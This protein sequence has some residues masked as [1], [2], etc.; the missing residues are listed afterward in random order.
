MSLDN[1]EKLAALRDKGI[2]SQEEF[3]RE[4]A[5]IFRETNSKFNESER[6]KAE[7]SS[8]NSSIEPNAEMNKESDQT[9][10]SNKKPFLFNL[11]ESGF[12]YLI[13]LSILA[14]FLFNLGILITVI[15]WLSEK[16]KSSL[17]NLHGKNA[18]NWQISYLI[19]ILAIRIVPFVDIGGFVY[20]M[21]LLFSMVQCILAT[22]KASQNEVWKYPGAIAFI[23]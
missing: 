1:L 8:I 6:S 23:K 13:H 16:D 4:K 21:V 3:E 12:I 11:S 20:N 18:V 7:P 10:N 2:I 9:V 14:N 5:K 19:L 22:I 15:L 17:V